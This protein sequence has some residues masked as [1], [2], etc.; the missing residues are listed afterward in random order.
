MEAFAEYSHAIASVV[1]FT[2]VVL[3]LAPFS[4]LAK[5]GKGLAP[6]ATPEQDYG[7]QAYRLNRAYLNGTETLPAFLTV[8][9]AAIL[10]GVSPFWVNLLA[11]V[12]LVAR[13]LMLVVHLR[14][15]GKPNSG[16]RS[17]LYVLGWACMFVIGLMA[18]V[19]AF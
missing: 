13:L 18:L 19:A 11:S 9:V 6:G 10:L 12:A 8:V 16:L 15:I 7:D 17:V 5:Q 2:L 4:A 3:F 1:F 14:G